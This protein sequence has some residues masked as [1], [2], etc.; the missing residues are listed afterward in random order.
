MSSPEDLSPNA[1]RTSLS[2]EPFSLMRLYQLISQSTLLAGSTD[3]QHTVASQFE[4]WKLPSCITYAFS[5]QETKHT[6]T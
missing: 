3:S 6:P 4:S 1:P 2:C 5:E